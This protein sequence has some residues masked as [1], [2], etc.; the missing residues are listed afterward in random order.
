MNKLILSTLL[1]AGVVCAGTCDKYI[2]NEN[3]LQNWQTPLY[4]GTYKLFSSTG[5]FSDG[6]PI[7]VGEGYVRS[8]WNIPGLIT[9]CNVKHKE[10]KYYGYDENEQDWVS[11][12]IITVY[13]EIKDRTQFIEG[14]KWNTKV[15]YRENG[16][17][18]W[19][20]IESGSNDINCYDR[21]G[22]KV[23]KR[24]NDPYYCK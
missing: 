13:C 9:N 11:C 19:S 12:Y 20:R 3:I 1:A 2:K 21:N 17:R 23:V 18:K 10:R 4:T 15:G 5:K 8:G 24:V 6:S 14:I 7:T 22:M 16:T